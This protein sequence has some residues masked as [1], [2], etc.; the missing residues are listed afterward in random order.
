M[1]S[2]V[3]IVD[4]PNKAQTFG[5]SNY[6][7]FLEK[8]KTDPY[9]DHIAIPMNPKQGFYWPEPNM[10]E[11]KKQTNVAQVV[12]LLPTSETVDVL[13]VSS[14]V[15]EDMEFGV[16][17]Y[18]DA[19]ASEF[20]VSIDY[21]AI[22]IVRNEI[23]SA[24]ISLPT[25]NDSA[26]YGIG[27]N[28][29]AIGIDTLVGYMQHKFGINTRLHVDK[30]RV[31]VVA[32]RSYR[33]GVTLQKQDSSYKSTRYKMNEVGGVYY[34]RN[35]KN[36]R[37]FVDRLYLFWRDNDG[38]WE[39]KEFNMT[40][41]H[42]YREST[43][44]HSMGTGIVKEGQHI[45]SHFLGLHGISKNHDCSNGH[46]AVV[47]AGLRQQTKIWAYRDSNRD[48]Y[49][50]LASLTKGSSG[51]LAYFNV[52]S[53]FDTCR[54]RVSPSETKKYY[55][56]RIHTTKTQPDDY[57]KGYSLGCQTIT[58]PDYATWTS[59]FIA[60]LQEHTRLYKYPHTPKGGIYDYTVDENNNRSDAT[61]ADFT[62]ILLEEWD[63]VKYMGENKIN[64]LDFN[65][66][67]FEQYVT[68]HLPTIEFKA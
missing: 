36:Y 38:R 9:V 22:I 20:N 35:N 44:Y 67:T 14:I 53:C 6:G 23:D 55:Q 54:Y 65:G 37:Q 39:L 40:T 57:V 24:T 60:P 46:R 32:I 26:S 58:V 61:V 10:E 48:G 50:E 7:E 47:Q 68:E 42:G 19:N 25:F 15:P 52:H 66:S 59:D 1:F 31:N 2:G 51:G 64:G 12:Y 5:V 49:Y 28:P 4:Y 29:Y 34:D 8:V 11:I 27:H 41:L 45:N 62:Y 33:D 56:R 18:T 13:R 63:L 17:E 30:N 16:Y 43:N 3:N 21:K